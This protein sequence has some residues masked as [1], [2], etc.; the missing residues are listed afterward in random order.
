MVERQ[1]QLTASAPTDRG[2]LYFSAAL[3]PY[4]V[5]NL[6]EHLLG[7]GRR[8]GR[9]VHVE[10]DLG[11]GTRDSPEYRSFETRMKRLRRQGVSVHI[12]AAR[13]RRRPYG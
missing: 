5:E 1:G 6:C 3:T 7:L 4:D 11:G 9:D 2:W 12:H 10:V 8:D 13:A